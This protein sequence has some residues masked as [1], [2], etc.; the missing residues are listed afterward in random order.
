MIDSFGQ[1]HPV[2]PC[3]RA[4]RRTLWKE[5]QGTRIWSGE[6]YLC[7]PP[8]V[9]PPKLNTQWDQ[10]LLTFDPV[11]LSHVARNSN[12]YEKP[13]Q[14]QRLITSMIGCGLLSA[15][16]LV[17][18]R[19]RRV[20]TPA[21]SIQNLRAFAPIMFE[22]GFRLRNRWRNIIGKDGGDG[23]VLDVCMWASRITFDVIGAAG[24]YAG[25]FQSAIQC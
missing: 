17:H 24:S 22:R 3:S 6:C 1:C 8:R 7:S 21:F 19:Q 13:W 14:T 11:A 16:G 12:D 25:F 4:D 5:R 9:T 15:E 23:A 18:K 2:R 10:R 20:A